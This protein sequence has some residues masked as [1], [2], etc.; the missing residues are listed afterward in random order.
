MVRSKA[1]RNIR[2]GGLWA[3]GK[4]LYSNLP[5]L[6]ACTEF[7]WLWSP[8]SKFARRPLDPKTSRKHR[9]PAE[10]MISRI[11]RISDNEGRGNQHPQGL[12][13]HRFWQVTHLEL[14][15]LWMRLSSRIWRFLSRSNFSS[16]SWRSASSFF[17]AAC[18]SFR[19]SS[20]S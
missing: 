8:T 7:W 4:T 20:C 12:P 19:I 6:W 18:R 5:V 2:G 11:Q 15:S 9:A 10:P 16:S 13:S 14:S 3:H 1:C 17:K